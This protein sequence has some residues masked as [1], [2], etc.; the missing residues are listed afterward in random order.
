MSR[1]VEYLLPVGEPDE[2]QHHSITA[3]T[4]TGS[5]TAFY[6][7]HSYS[8]VSAVILSLWCITCYEELLIIAP[9]T[10]TETWAV[11][12]FGMQYE[13]CGTRYMYIYIYIYIYETVFQGF[14]EEVMVFPASD[15]TRGL[16]INPSSAKCTIFR[17]NQVSAMTAVILAKC[18][19]ISM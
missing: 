1:E 18:A 11:T 2:L 7:L 5:T 15:G 9:G 17:E 4:H 6:T 16:T 19:T 3:K 8:F 10:N 12:N 14:S 13:H